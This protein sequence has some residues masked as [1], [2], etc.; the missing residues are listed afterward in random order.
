MSRPPVG[1]ALLLLGVAAP[2]AAQDRLLGLRA[3]GAGVTAEAIWFGG[4]GVPQANVVGADS[5]RLTRVSQLSVPITAVTPLGG[6]WTLDATTVYASGSV[7]AVDAAV[8]GTLDR[9][10]RPLDL[11][12]TVVRSAGSAGDP[13]F[14]S[15]I[16][17]VVIRVTRP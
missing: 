10:N 6:S 9:L 5:L 3:A 8:A 11:L 16:A 4:E 12:T 1:R 17:T 2:L 14:P 15:T 7:R 13:S